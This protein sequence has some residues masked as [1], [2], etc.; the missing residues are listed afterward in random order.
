M[1]LSGVSFPHCLLALTRNASDVERMLLTAPTRTHQVFQPR[2]SAEALYRGG[3]VLTC[4]A[5][6][7]FVEDLAL[8]AV[9]RVATRYNEGGSFTPAGHEVAARNARILE[10]EALQAVDS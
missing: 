5:W 9:R 3:V 6:E 8:E 10:R 7:T 4:A 1:N 2:L